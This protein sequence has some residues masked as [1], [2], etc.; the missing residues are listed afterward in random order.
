MCFIFQW[1]IELWMYVEQPFSTPFHTEELM[2]FSLPL[3]V[4]LLDKLRCFCKLFSKKNPDAI[5]TL[6]LGFFFARFP[7]SPVAYLIP[8]F[9]TR[10]IA[11]RRSKGSEYKRWIF[12]GSFLLNVFWSVLSTGEKKNMLNIFITCFIR[13]FSLLIYCFRCFRC[14]CCCSSCS[15]TA[16]GLWWSLGLGKSNIILAVQQQSESGR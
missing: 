5:G 15:A 10:R 8:V 1:R 7:A 6:L 16:K 3:Y 4:L 11:C 13:N 12:P 14:V 2:F 9:L